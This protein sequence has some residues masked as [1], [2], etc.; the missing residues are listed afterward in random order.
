MCHEKHTVLVLIYGCRK[1]AVLYLIDIKV[2]TLVSDLVPC[3]KLAFVT[4]FSLAF[5]LN[6]NAYT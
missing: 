6:I 2:L 4:R 3:L 5:S 1:K